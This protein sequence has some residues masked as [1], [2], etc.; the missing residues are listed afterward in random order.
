[1]G[2]NFMLNAI[3]I[4]QLTREEK[5][6]VMEALWED[7]SDDEEQVVSPDWNRKALQETESRF[8]SGKEMMLDLQDAKKEIRKRSE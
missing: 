6:R 3:E 2:L 5:L 4:K 8:R 1:M 7:L